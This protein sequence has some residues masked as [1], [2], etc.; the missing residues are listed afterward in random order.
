MKVAQS[1]PT[2]C[3]Q[4]RILDWAALSFS[5]GSSQPRDQT[6]VSRIAG[7]FFTSWAAR[8]ASTL[9]LYFLLFAQIS[10]F[11]HALLSYMTGS[12]LYMWS[13]Q[14]G[15]LH[16][17]SCLE[18]SKNRGAFRA[19]VHAAAESQ[20]QL[21]LAQWSTMCMW[22]IHWYIHLYGYACICCC[23]SLAQLCP[24][25]CNP[26]DGSTPVFPVHHHLQELTQAHGHW[27]GGVI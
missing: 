9:G 3:N 7:G 8:E 21:G 11:L 12:L 25:L 14:N 10:R 22:N 16:H 2:L 1:C 27:V 4:A 15:T 19:T 24:T 23:C 20:T 18:N 26:V 6:R 17:Y 5:T 13:I